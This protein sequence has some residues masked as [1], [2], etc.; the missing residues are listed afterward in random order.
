MIGVDYSQEMLNMAIEKENNV[1]LYC[2]CCQ[3]MRRTRF[4]WN[5][6]SSSKPL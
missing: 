4:V 3:D 5:G 6:G 1:R 2:I